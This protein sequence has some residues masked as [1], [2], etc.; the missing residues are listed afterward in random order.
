MSASG[1]FS[2]WLAKVV[3]RSLICS[4]SSITMLTVA[5][6]VAALSR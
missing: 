4:L 5:R 3:S 2:K 6:V 1:C